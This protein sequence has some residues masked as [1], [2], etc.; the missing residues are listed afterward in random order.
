MKEGGRR[1]LNAKLAGI[2]HSTIVVTAV[3]LPASVVFAD[4][5]SPSD[6][7]VPADPAPAADAQPLGTD[8]KPV[9]QSSSNFNKTGRYLPGEEVVT[10]TGKKVKIWSTEGPV[11]VNPPAQQYGDQAGW[12][13]FSPNVIID[14]D[15]RDHDHDGH[16]DDRDDDRHG[17]RGHGSDGRSGDDRGHGHEGQGGGYRGDGHRGDGYRGGHRGGDGRHR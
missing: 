3:T 11:P 9:D 12:G 13:S 7:A 15:D 14:T 1:A 6:F 16:H 17:N 5:E 4:G 10:P 8:G 2:V